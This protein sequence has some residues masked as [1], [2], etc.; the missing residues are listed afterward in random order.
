MTTV[1]HKVCY[2]GEPGLPE[3][4]NNFV[5][6]KGK[7]AYVQYCSEEHKKNLMNLG[8]WLSFLKIIVLC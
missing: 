1:E 8:G 4:F 7:V 5:R 3:H 2:C 6:R